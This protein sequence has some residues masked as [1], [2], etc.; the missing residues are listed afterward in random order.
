MKAVAV[1]LALCAVMMAAS[2]SMGA[3]SESCKTCSQ[4][5]TEFIS[6][7]H[8][9]FTD[10]KWIQTFCKMSSIKTREFCRS[11]LSRFLNG[12]DSG[13]Q[14]SNASRLCAGIS[15]CPVSLTKCA[16]CQFYMVASG[17]YLTS[18]NGYEKDYD[19][20]FNATCNLYPDELGINCTSAFKYSGPTFDWLKDKLM[21]MYSKPLL[22][23]KLFRMCHPA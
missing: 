19:W 17:D 12:T 7:V 18:P 15:T 22:Y 6:I 4:V 1:G 10:V 23:C 13:V 14:T 3:S 8:K 9:G 20:L 5:A 16:Y 2:V 21:K 11:Y